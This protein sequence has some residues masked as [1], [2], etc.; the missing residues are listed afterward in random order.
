MC[1]TQEKGTKILN[2]SSYTLHLKE[3]TK[4]IDLPECPHV[5]CYQHIYLLV[6]CPLKGTIFLTELSHWLG[7]SFLTAAIGRRVFPLLP[8]WEGEQF[9]L[10]TVLCHDTITGN[11]TVNRKHYQVLHDLYKSL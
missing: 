11:L 4:D 5:I 7:L 1:S 8:P 6:Q 9:L 3:L 2:K 10:R